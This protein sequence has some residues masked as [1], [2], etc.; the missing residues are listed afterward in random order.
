MGN[1]IP[2]VANRKA[3][4]DGVRAN[5]EKGGGDFAPILKLDQDGT[6]KYGMEDEPLEDGT[7]C[8]VLPSSFVHG[9]TCWK[10]GKPVDAV[11]GPIWEPVAAEN[12]LPDHGPYK[13][14]KRG[15]VLSTEGWSATSGA[16]FVLESGEK[17]RYTPMSYG[18]RTALG[19]L[20]TA[21]AQ[22]LDAD[23]ADCIPVVTL[24][25]RSYYNKNYGTDVQVPV[26]E[27][28]KWLTEQEA[29]LR[30]AEDGGDKLEA[31]AKEEAKK[32]AMEW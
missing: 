17:L 12:S 25:S 13:T 15:N 28:V 11:I 30:A 9:W 4:V 31:P 2:S 5:A 10:S 20:A 3:I 14:D 24:E 23:A 16:A 6:W 29:E 21:F 26:L 27:V 1:L 32:P 19:E 18:G 7:R 8:M 22:R